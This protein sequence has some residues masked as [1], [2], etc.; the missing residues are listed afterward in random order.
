MEDICN[1]TAVGGLRV[2]RP[3]ES[4]LQLE[5]ELAVLSGEE[6]VATGAQLSQ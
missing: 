5:P 4:S 2:Q 3:S 1:E 6:P